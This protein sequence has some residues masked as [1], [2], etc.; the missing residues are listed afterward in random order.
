M[1]VSVIIPFLNDH[2]ALQRTLRHLMP[3]VPGGHG[4]VIIIDNGSYEPLKLKESPRLR[5]IRNRINVGVGGAFNQGVELSKADT[6]VLMG[7]DTIPQEGW[8][9]RVLETIKGNENTIFNCVSSGFTGQQRPHRKSSR[10][11]HGAHILFKVQKDDLPERSKLRDLPTF[12]HILQAK[13]NYGQPETEFTP[14]K[15]L[16]G[17]FYWMNKKQYQ[18]LHGW[19]GHR[20]WGSLEP[21][22]S[23]KAR[24]HGMHIMVD[25]GLEAAHYYGRDPIRPVR[26]DLQFFNMLFMA[27]TMFTEA[28][29]NDLIEYLR[30]GDREEKIEKLNVNQ[31]RVMIKR[32]MGLV[33]AERDYNNKHFKHGLIANW[34]QFNTEMI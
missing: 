21:F 11:R 3:D 33:L 16:L 24:A 2:E 8:F 13:W 25:A 12:S 17:A 4:E 6:I 20:M 29:R 7:C 30:Y 14:V 27:H 9:D 32:Q 18:R 31:A 34:E 5:V 26:H 22:L 19:N 1:K 10:R 28:L 23:L 15:C